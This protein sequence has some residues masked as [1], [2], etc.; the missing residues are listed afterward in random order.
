M[1]LVKSKLKYR[2]EY[3]RHQS[4]QSAIVAKVSYRD[5]PIITIKQPNLL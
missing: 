5:E 1:K 4:T 3:C 2:C